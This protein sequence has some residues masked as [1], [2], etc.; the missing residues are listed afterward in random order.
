MATLACALLEALSSVPAAVGREDLILAARVAADAPLSFLWPRPLRSPIDGRP[1]PKLI[2]T[3]E[4][5]GVM[6]GV[7]PSTIKDLC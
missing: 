4:E 2:Y 6:F 7:R 3:V 5:V 1:L